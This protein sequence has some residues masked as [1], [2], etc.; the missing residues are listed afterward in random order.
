MMQRAGKQGEQSASPNREACCLCE[1]A[2]GKRSPTDEWAQ[3]GDNTPYEILLGA[4]DA[5]SAI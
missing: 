1:R 5:A 2:F 3:P 4:T